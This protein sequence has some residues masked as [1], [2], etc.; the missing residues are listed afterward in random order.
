VLTL[1]RNTAC[2]VLALLLGGAI[3]ESAA[4]RPLATAGA[5]RVGKLMFVHVSVNGVGPFWF[6]LDSGAPHSSVDP[7]L[8]QRAGLKT[9]GADT[10]TGTGK[11]GVPI[12][13][14]EPAVFSLAGLRL[15]I[16]EPWVIDLSGVPIPKWTHGLVGAEFFENY[17][18]EVDPET[19]SLSFFDPAAFAAPSSTAVVPLINE[20]HRLYLNATLEVNDHLEAER[21][22]RIDLGSEESVADTL[23]RQGSRVRTTTLGQGLGQ[24]YQGV[25]GVLQAV[26]LGPYRFER[27]W[28]PESPRPAIGMEFFRRFTATFDASRGKLYLKPNRHL[29]EPV[30]EPPR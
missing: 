25:S 18:V 23:V 3:P 13:H 19:P 21:K 20:N 7:Y 16:E 17:V 5:K 28:G 10:I 24:N 22:L 26:R 1:I 6:C 11:G 12:E 4:S 9:V 8:L 27:V 30:P 15:R 14:A 29:H 2:F